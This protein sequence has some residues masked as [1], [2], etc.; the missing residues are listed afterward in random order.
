M[1]MRRITRTEE[2]ERRGKLAVKWGRN[3]NIMRS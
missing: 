2:V 1:E 3:D